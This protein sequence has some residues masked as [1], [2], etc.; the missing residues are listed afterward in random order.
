MRCKLIEGTKE[1]LKATV[2]SLGVRGK[3]DLKPV[4]TVV[5]DVIDNIRENGDAALL[6]YTEKFDGVKLTSDQLRVSEKEIEEGL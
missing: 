6:G 3:M 5:Q 1:N 2:Q 4:I